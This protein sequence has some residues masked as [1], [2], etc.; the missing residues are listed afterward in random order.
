MA[1]LFGSHNFR[2]LSV[3][4]HYL[5]WFIITF[6][7]FQCVNATCGH[8]YHPKC[9]S[10]LLHRE[11]KIAAEELERKIASGESFSCPVHKCSVCELGENKK[12]HELQF[13]VCRRCPKSYHRK[14]LPRYHLYFCMV[15]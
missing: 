2:Q 11:N 14:C 3:F 5:I 10:K 12:V 4:D 1:P 9:V 15:N 8:F 7:V 6:Q 13:A